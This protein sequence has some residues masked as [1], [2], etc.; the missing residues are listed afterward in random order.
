MCDS[1]KIPKIDR[2][3]KLHGTRTLEENSYDTIMYFY[4]LYTINYNNDI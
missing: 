3:E 4:L 2:I 1:I